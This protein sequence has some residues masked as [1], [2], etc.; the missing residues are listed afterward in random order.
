MLVAL[1]SVSIASRRLVSKKLRK[2]G[3]AC[4]QRGMVA[5]AC[6]SPSVFSWGDEE[7]VTLLI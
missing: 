7:H 4:G 3:K 2:S 6:L 5:L 1:S